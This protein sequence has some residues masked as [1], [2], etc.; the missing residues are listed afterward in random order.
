[1]ARLQ[2]DSSSK[3]TFNDRVCIATSLIQFI[4]LCIKNSSWQ[5]FNDKFPKSLNH[6]RECVPRFSNTSATDLIWDSCSYFGFSDGWICYLQIR[7]QLKE[8][9][10]KICQNKTLPDWIQTFLSQLWTKLQIVAKRTINP[11]A[12]TGVD[13][14]VE[15]S[16]R[17]P[18]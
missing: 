1:M 7:L 4:Q 17:Y 10:V 15:H 6:R 13:N 5:S 12:R 18:T 2:F 11:L 9:S 16:N 14:S 3:V 8:F